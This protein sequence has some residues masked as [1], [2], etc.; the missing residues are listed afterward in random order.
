MLVR[1]FLALPLKD[2]ENNINL[3]VRYVS[4]GDNENTYT[5]VCE[6]TTVF[7]RIVIL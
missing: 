1:N 3:E 6:M 5:Y 2:E 7:P 4:F